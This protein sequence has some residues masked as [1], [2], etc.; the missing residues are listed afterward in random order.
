[1]PLLPILAGLVQF[2]PIAASWLGG[3]KAEE[4]AASVVGMAKA[5]TGTSDAEA[6]LS[7]LQSRPD[8]A[9]QFQQAV[10]AQQ[11]DLARLAATTDV[12]L[13]QAAVEDRASARDMHTSMDSVIP[14]VL[15]AVITIGFFGVLLGLLAG[16]LT[17]ANNEVL[18]LL[19]G[20]LASGWAS[21]LAFYYGSSTG[22]KRKGAQL[23][24]RP[25]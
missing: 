10:L 1:M 16:W 7:S 3:P 2:A 21:M 11:S 24:Q 18:L 4:V 20:T 6:A 14:A 5:I 23:E 17:T 15:A 12:Q 8:L 19:L 13:E 22:S 9:L 25:R